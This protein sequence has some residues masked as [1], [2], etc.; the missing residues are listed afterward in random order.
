MHPDA[1]W[2]SSWLGVPRQRREMCLQHSAISHVPSGTLHVPYTSQG[3]PPRPRHRRR[4]CAGQGGG[5]RP[6]PWSACR[7]ETPGG[8]GPK[9][10]HPEGGG[11]GRA[12]HL[13]VILPMAG[14]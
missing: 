14:A 6:G 10:T 13:H 9:G 7:W 2:Q 4:Q 1:S 5:R 3:E 11:V 8:V 12:S